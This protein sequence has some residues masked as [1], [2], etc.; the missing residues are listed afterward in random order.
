MMD[1]AWAAKTLVTEY[2]NH[3]LPKRLEKYRNHWQLD[4]DLLP[5]PQLI[6]QH[7]PYTN[8]SW[9]MLTTLVLGTQDIIREDYD[10][11]DNPIY[12]VRYSMR[13]YVY[14]RSVG[15][16]G[17]TR[18]RD[19]W[20]TVIRS[21][22]LDHPALKSVPRFEHC[23]PMVDEG[24]VQ[25]TFSDL[26]PLK[27]ERWWAGGYISYDMI[28]R[29]TVS[30]PPVMQPGE[31]DIEVEG[32]IMGEKWDDGSWVKTPK[33]PGAPGWI[34]AYANGDGSVTLEWKQPLWFG[35]V[36]PIDWYEL[37]FSKDDGDWEDLAR[38]EQSHRPRPHRVVTGLDLGS[39]YRFRV[40]AVNYYGQSEFSDPSNAVI[41]TIEEE[42]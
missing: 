5:D 37:Q 42:D 12:R 20:V 25:E 6:I 39:T 10:D 28:V 35:G 14:V 7:E 26:E 31:W 36:D 24:T 38:D 3:D 33:T 11:D 27:G 8:D 2:L 9:P 32:N 30:R 13:T 41:P 4:E 16:D 18:M 22:L 23:D 1:G 19:N 34:L 40:S 21:A 17:V 29:E 15:Q